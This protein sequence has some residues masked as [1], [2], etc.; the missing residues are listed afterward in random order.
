[1]IG[2]LV[3]CPRCHNEIADAVVEC[4]HCHIVVAQ[5]LKRQREMASGVATS[6]PPAP[7]KEEKKAPWLWLLALLFAVGAGYYLLHFN[8][9]KPGPQPAV[10]VVPA[11]P[12]TPETTAAPAPPSSDAPETPQ[13]P[14]DAPPPQGTPPTD[15]SNDSNA[16]AESFEKG[17][18]R[19]KKLV[20]A[21][22]PMLPGN[23]ERVLDDK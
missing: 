2:G 15:D 10:V 19:I 8:R 18:K 3:E 21:A 13:A 17:E 20:R 9:H 4:P 23:P 14:S 11:A 1:M 6:V 22:S 7:V 12:K 16:S 5:Y